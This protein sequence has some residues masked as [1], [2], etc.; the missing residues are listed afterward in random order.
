M[1]DSD[2]TYTE[3]AFDHDVV[4]VGGGPAGCAAGIFTARYGLD[5]VIFDR[6]RSSIQRCAHLENYLG[7]PAGIDIETLYELMHDHAEEAGC[8]IVPDLVESLERTDDGEGFII[9]LQ[10]VVPITARRVIAATRYDGE[11]MRGLDDEAAMFETHEHD[12]EEHEHFDKGYAESDGTTPV[13]DLFI[14]SPYGDTGY[15]A[16]MAAGRG[17]RTAIS[18]VEAVRRE[19]GYPDSLANYYDWVRRETE[20]EDES[21]ARNRWR[22]HFDDRVA[23]DHGLE[24]ARLAELRDREIDRRIEMYISDDE[25]DRRGERG[26]ERLLEHIDDELILDAARAI[27]AER[28]TATSN[29]GEPTARDSR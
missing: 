15:Q 1:S 21:A 13:D 16:L 23:D 11:Y 26:Q 28:R 20:L 27:E 18:V 7:F 9:D 12:G 4:V 19:R 5:T 2:T 29:N 14:A 3:A 10:G 22:E 25:I 24:E 8:E 17:A 6:G